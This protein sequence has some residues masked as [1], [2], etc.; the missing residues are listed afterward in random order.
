MKVLV[1]I[2]VVVVA[3]AIY[4]IRMPGVFINPQFW[5]EDGGLFFAQSLTDGW[6]SVLYPGAG[7]LTLITRAIANL[8]RYFGAMSAPAIYNYA[9]AAIALASVWVLLRRGLTSRI[10][11]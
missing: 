8:A 11:R 9:A 5:G 7:Y 3:T 2:V 1:R 10:S 6:I 4:F